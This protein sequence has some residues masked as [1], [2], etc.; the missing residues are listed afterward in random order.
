MGSN[1]LGT[2]P[3]CMVCGLPCGVWS[4]EF[5][6]WIHQGCK[7]GTTQHITLP[8]TP[9]PAYVA[10][11]EAAKAMREAATDAYKVGRIDALAFVTLGNAIDN[12]EREMRG[13]GA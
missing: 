5:C 12:A 2:Q 11:V 3:T 4:S 10:L 6:G 8:R 13:G 9:S 1:T 7:P